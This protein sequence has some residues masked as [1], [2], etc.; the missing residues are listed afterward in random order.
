MKQLED[1]DA[2]AA[3]F[4]IDTLDARERVEVVARRLRYADTEAANGQP[5]RLA[6]GA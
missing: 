3:D 5:V 6:G 4:V 2:L 1:I